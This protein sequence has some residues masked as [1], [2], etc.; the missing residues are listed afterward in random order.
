VLE[1]YLLAQDFQVVEVVDFPVEVRV[2]QFA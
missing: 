2:V 1:Y